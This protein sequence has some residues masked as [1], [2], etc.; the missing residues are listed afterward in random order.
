MRGGVEVAVVD[1]PATAAAELLA[2][3]AARGGNVALSGGA[4]PVPAYEV[5][6]ALAP[7][8]SRVGLW[9]ADERAVPPNDERSNHRLVRT[10]LLERLVEPP[11]RIHRIR[12]ELGAAE[13]ASVYE[14]ELIGVRLD[15]VL[16]GIGPDGHTASLFPYAPALTEKERLV[17]AAPAGLEPLVDRVTLTPLAISQARLLVFLVTGAE[18]AEA[19]R[20]ALAAPPDPGTPAS[21]VRAARTR[22][23]LDR[24]AASRLA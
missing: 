22:A 13:A 24:A 18:K 8:W 2:A 11:A 3:A 10:H 1:D 19:V 7:D 5:A 14:R 16:A 6:S 17:V 21:L 23:L 9:F 12:G 20:R 4:T 15:L